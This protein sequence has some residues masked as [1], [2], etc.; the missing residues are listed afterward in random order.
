MILKNTDKSTV[1]AILIFIG[2]VFIQS[3]SSSAGGSTGGNPLESTLPLQ[4]S[5]D[6]Q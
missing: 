5:V 3:C 2:L 6:G 4:I 1:F